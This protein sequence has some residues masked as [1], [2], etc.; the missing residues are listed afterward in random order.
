MRVVVCRGCLSSQVSMEHD[1]RNCVELQWVTQ[2]WVK[3]E[4]KE[5]LSILSHL[6]SHWE[7]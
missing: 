4:L 5:N 2:F 6:S 3:T 1:K 7:L